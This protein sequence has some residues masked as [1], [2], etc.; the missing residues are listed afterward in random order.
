MIYNLGAPALQGS[1]LV[2]KGNAGDLVGM[3]EQ[4][5]RWVRGTVNGQKTAL[6][7][8]VVCRDA[9]RELCAERGRDGHFSAGLLARA[10]GAR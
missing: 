10:G 4:M 6:P 2:A 3:F 9:T 7:G 8:L 5:P 1:A